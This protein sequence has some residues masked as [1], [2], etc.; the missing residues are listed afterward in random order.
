[1][2]YDIFGLTESQ[3]IGFFLA[4]IR[5]GALISVAPILGSQS[6]PAQLKVFLALLLS[7]TMLPAIK[8]Q[9]ELETITL[10]GLS[11]LIFKEVVLGL[12][13]GFNA[14]FIFESYQ[15]AGSLVS[16]QMGLGMANLVDPDSGQPVTPI[17]NI[18]TLFIMLVFLFLNGHHILISA[19]YKSFEVSPTGGYGFI[20]EGAQLK[21]VS[22]FNELFIIGIK[23]AA[24]S[25][26][27]V[28]LIEVCMAIMARIVPQ[29][30]IF[31]IGLPVRLGIGLFIVIASLPM[32]YLFFSNHLL[33]WTHDIFSI[34]KFF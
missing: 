12:F 16:T 15:F 2:F 4:F 1:M 23:L 3:F 5:I 13:L 28:F 32:Y 21:M 11:P 29:M 8:N 14:K 9:P 18:Y 7:V 6:I 19:L 34:L 27:T 24:P 26:A 30:N 22:L 20:L 33:S 31:F 25:M 17:G 10:I